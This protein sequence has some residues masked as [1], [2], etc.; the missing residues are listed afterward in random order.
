M[1]KHDLQ[2]VIDR[3]GKDY[4]S[5][6]L[7]IQVEHSARALGPGLGRFHFENLEWA[8]D[9]FGWF[10]KL[11]RGWDKGFSNIKDQKIV[12]NRVVAKDL[13]EALNGF[14]ILHLSDLH[15]DVFEGMGAHIGR[16]C[17]TLNATW[18]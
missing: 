8:L 3:C 14:K 5:K 12:F 1:E 4:V 9:A 7:Q 11:F 17:S 10:V 2:Q 6:R 18:P 16:L 13:P 15:L